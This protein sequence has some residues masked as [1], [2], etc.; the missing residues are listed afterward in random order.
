MADRAGI[1]A[2]WGERLSELAWLGGSLVLVVG[3]TALLGPE[4]AMLAAYGSVI[5]L[6]WLVD[7]R[8]GR[9]EF[10][11]AMRRMA[12]FALLIGWLV[13]TR[14]VPPLAQ[15]LEQAGRMQPF[16][17][18]PAW[19][20]LFHAGTWLVAGAILTGVVRGHTAAL[21]V[22]IRAAW[23]TGRLAVFTIIVFS[24]MAELLSGSGIAEGLAR[25]MFAA[26]DRWAIV[27]TPL[28]SAVF[29][30]LANSGNAANGLF[31]AS[32][33]SLAMEAGLHL[34]AVIGLQHAAALS[35]N[36][37]SPVRMSIVCS[38]AGTSGREREVYLLML[39]FAAVI[40]G[41]LFTCSMLVAIRAF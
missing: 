26:L 40:L 37:V 24:M 35:L 9:R 4:T 15:F 1:G 17:G 31:M 20:P 6:R 3:A 16:E 7:E 2:G 41:V 22:E 13:M 21:P 19:P 5:V 23:K 25:G 18:V 28:I 33:V 11:L 12:P 38:L 30:A 34:A 27:V 39:P 29:G 36:L 14:L 10:S 32:Q 8:P